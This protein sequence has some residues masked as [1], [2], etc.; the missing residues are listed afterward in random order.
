MH[1]SVA[2]VN[3]ML[4]VMECFN[5]IRERAKS[6]GRSDVLSYLET[7][8]HAY[9]HGRVTD[10]ALVENLVKYAKNELA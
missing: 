9:Y 1:D 3:G 6:R 8:E 4:D 7:V 10:E 2:E 5:M